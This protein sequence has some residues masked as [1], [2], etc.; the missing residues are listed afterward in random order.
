MSSRFLSPKGLKGLEKV[1]DIYIP[2]NKK[3]ASFSR[4]GKL[5]TVDDILNELPKD[6]RDGLVILLAV[7]SYLPKVMLRV[8]IWRLSQNKTPIERM[9]NLGLKGIAHTIYYSKESSH[10]KD[11]IMDIIQF[12]AKTESKVNDT[13][14]AELSKS[15]LSYRKKVQDEIRAISFGEKKRLLNAL[16][17][18]ILERQEEIIS[19][20]Q[21]ETKKSRTDALTSEIFGVLDHLDFLIKEGEKCLKDKKVKTP[22]ALMGKKSYVHFE[23]LGTILVISPW[24]YPFYQAI[25]PITASFF[26]GNFTLYKP[27]ELTPLKGLIEDILIKSGFQQSWFEIHYGAG[28]VGAKLI[29]QNPDKIFFTGSVA[30]GKKIAEVAGKNLIPVELELG[31]KD[32][33][34]VFE[35]VNLLRVVK[36]ALWGGLTNAGQS[37]TSVER[38]YVHEDI[39]EPFRDLMIIEAN[40]IQTGVDTDGSTDFG[41]MTSTRQVEIVASHLEDALNKG[42]IQLTGHDWDKKSSDIPPIILENVN[43]N[44]LV[45]TEETFGPIIPLMQFSSEEEVIRLANDSAYGLSASVWSKD[46]T[47]ATR[48]SNLLE[49]GNVSINNV[50]LTEGNHAL[51]FGGVKDSGIGRYKGEFGLHSFSN[52]KSILVDKDSKLIE[53]NWYPYT[54]TK[55]QLFTG[56]M[57]GLFGSGIKGLI[58][59]AINGLKLECYSDKIGKSGR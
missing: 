47:R 22:I 21:A 33:M 27:S 17:K 15:D 57:R 26:A 8:I 45:T 52:I 1:G 46:L 18:Q 3:S 51:P 36:G 28:D 37:C 5:H 31:G 30:T 42:A 9:L 25:V 2:G 49:T 6:D 4:V 44:M 38:L 20:V 32:P 19:K 11:P 56:M 40:K 16:K 48:V 14:L 41:G 50:M 54:P 39:Y 34:I 7:F 55:Y 59:F 12:D 29:E 58:G 24:N 53:A 13:E 43:N 23:P 10:K 35:D